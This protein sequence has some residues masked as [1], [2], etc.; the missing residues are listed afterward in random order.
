MDN[1]SFK[2]IGK[3]NIFD[4]IPLLQKI[5]NKTPLEILKK[6]LMEMTT[7]NYECAGVYDGNKLIGIC[8]IWYMTRHYIGKSMEV[9]HVVIDAAYRS[10]GIGKKFFDWIY[11]YAKE[12]GC[13]ASELNTY[14]NNP[15][16]H[17]FYYNEGYN[18]YGF[19]FLKILRNDQKFY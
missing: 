17:K 18:I 7:Q 10:K 13:E 9:D 19:H 11:N 4:I 6:R 5:N 14:V 1:I 8:G 15:K 12:K 2:I 16:S 3:E